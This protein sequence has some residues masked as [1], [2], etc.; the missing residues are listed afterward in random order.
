MSKLLEIVMILTFG[1][2]WPLNLRKAW[3]AG[4]AR[5]TSMGFLL[6][7]LLGYAAGIAAK[8]CNESFMADFGGNWYVLA[9]YVMNFTLVFLDLMVYFRNRRL[10][11]RTEQGG[12]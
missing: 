5:G 10:D 7:I 11:R 4:T 1:A 8:L 12:R 3:Q 2:S 6:L 9:C